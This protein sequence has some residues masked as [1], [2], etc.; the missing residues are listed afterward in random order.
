MRRKIYRCDTFDE[1]TAIV[2][3]INKAQCAANLFINTVILKTEYGY[4]VVMG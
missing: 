4:K 1:A 3:A 2:A